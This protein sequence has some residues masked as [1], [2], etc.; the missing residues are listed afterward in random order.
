MSQ[1]REAVYT[2]LSRRRRRLGLVNGSAGVGLAGCDRVVADGYQG[3]PNQR[4]GCVSV[5][6]PAHSSWPLL[7]QAR[8]APLHAI[9]LESLGTVG[10]GILVGWGMTA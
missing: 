2:E 5:R 4:L 9:G 10:P 1:R 3:L 8:T 6:Q 7:M